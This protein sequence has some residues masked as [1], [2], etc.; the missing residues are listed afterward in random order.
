MFLAMQ[1]EWAK[2]KAHA[3]RWDKE[4]ILTVKEMCQQSPS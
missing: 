4:F 1:V 3:D 2:T